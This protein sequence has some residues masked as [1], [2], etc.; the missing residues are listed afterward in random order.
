[1]K[2]T[3]IR[4]LLS[5]FVVLAVVGYLLTTI[6]YGSL[7]PL[8]PLA[9]VTLLVL[10]ALELIWAFSLKARIDRKPNTRPLNPLVAARSVAL[11]KASGLVGSGLA[12]LWAGLLVFVLIR[13]SE[14][15]AAADDTPSTVI[16]L[17]SAVSLAAAGLWLEH[18]CRTPPTDEDDGSSRDR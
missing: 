10:A 3:S 8:P 5:L 16:G 9:G 12:G 13:R 15:A 1:M 14:L 7:P 18:C 4:D 6:V 2:P 17:F 11:A